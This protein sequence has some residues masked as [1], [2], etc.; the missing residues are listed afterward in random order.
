[1]PPC[2]CGGTISTAADAHIST[3][4][5]THTHAQWMHTDDCIFIGRL[6]PAPL[7]QAP[8]QVP[9]CCRGNDGANVNIR[10]YVPNRRMSSLVCLPSWCVSVCMFTFSPPGVCYSQLTT[11]AQGHRGRIQF[12][13]WKRNSREGSLLIPFL[14]SLTDLSALAACKKIAVNFSSCFPQS[15]GCDTGFCNRDTK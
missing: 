6:Q 7:Y 3:H 5:R 11:P 2:A 1:M 14:R 8:P 9:G 15:F 10:D 13:N 12:A 4:R